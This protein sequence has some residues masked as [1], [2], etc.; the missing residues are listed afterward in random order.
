MGPPT[1][2]IFV[3]RESLRNLEADRRLLIG[4]LRTGRITTPFKKPGTIPGP[5]TVHQ[6]VHQKVSVGP[7]TSREVLVRRAAYPPPP[8]FMPF[9]RAAGGPWISLYGVPA[10]GVG[11]GVAGGV[12]GTLGG[13]SGGGTRPS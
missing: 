4:D 1:L 5:F 2:T 11:R 3:R 12:G 13:A 9:I 6:K 10:G 8:G 7:V